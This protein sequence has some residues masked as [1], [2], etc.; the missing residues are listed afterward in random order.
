[1]LKEKNKKIIHLFNR[2]KNKRSF[3]YIDDLIICIQELIK[4]KS[5][6]FKKNKYECLNIGNEKFYSVND[7]INI[8]KKLSNNSYKFKIKNLN[9]KDIDPYMTKSNNKKLYKYIKK[10][11]FKTL[12][13]GLKI[14][15]NW[16]A[17]NH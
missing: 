16:F 14:F 6:I 12:E 13:D 17:I 8:Y 15:K 11:N 4:N 1:M 10:I 3:T 7:L 5:S 2:G 9:S